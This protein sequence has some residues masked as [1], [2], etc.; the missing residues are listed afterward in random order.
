MDPARP[1]ER[2][3]LDRAVERL[4]SPFALEELSSLAGPAALVVDIATEAA[5][6]D[7]GRLAVAGERLPAIAC[8]TIALGVAAPGS[9]GATLRRRF[10]VAVDSEDELAPLLDA[11]S[12]RPIAATAL[13]QLLR[14]GEGLTVHEALIA[15]SLVYSTL[16][17]GPEMAAWLAGNPGKPA[18]KR[19]DEPAV[20]VERR[21]ARLDLV[22]NRPE[23]RNA[24]SAEMRDALAQGLAL[25][26]ADPSI[27]E[28]VLTG[29]GP[30]FSAGGDLAEFGTLPDPATAH[31]IRST[32]NAGRLLAMCADR[33]RAELHGA[34]VGAGIELPA[35]AKRVVAKPDA[36]FELPE[37]SMGLVPGAG[38]TASIARRIGRQRTAYLALTGIRLDAHTALAWGLIDEIA[39]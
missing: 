3:S 30:A 35:F 5:I 20:L 2:L 33:V 26:V 7:A 6:A 13:V 16:Q 21:D 38:G 24:Y 36:F 14:H 25:A 1:P 27:K 17:A 29:R 10:D 8:P 11:V 9:H 39:G 37:V 15:E 4:L 31:L 22:L 23:R 34:C 32:R 19:N 18:L 12:A 28:I